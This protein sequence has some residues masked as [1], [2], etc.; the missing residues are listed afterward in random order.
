MG[1]EEVMYDEGVIG[2][3]GSLLGVQSVIKRGRGMGMVWFGSFIWFRFI[4][5]LPTPFLFP[6]PKTRVWSWISISFHPLAPFSSIVQSMI[7]PLFNPFSLLS[8]MGSLAGAARMWKNSACVQRAAQRGRKPLVDQKGKSW[9]EQ[10]FSVGIVHT[11]VRPIDP[12]G[13]KQ[14]MPKWL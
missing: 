10:R 2:G 7:L 12:L 3:A 1:E 5:F 14:T 4:L 6:L 11:K 9:F 13:G 8:L